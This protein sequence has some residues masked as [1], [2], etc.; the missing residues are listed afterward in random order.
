[1]IAPTGYDNKEAEERIISA[2][3]RTNPNKPIVSFT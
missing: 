3:D 1:V 2:I